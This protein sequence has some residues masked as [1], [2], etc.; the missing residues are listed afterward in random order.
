MAG[1]RFSVAGASERY[2]LAVAC[3]ILLTLAVFF[4]RPALRTDVLHH[5]DGAT[6]LWVAGPWL[7]WCLALVCGAR[8]MRRR[9]YLP[10]RLG[11]LQW[12]LLNAAVGAV[13]TLPFTF[14]VAEATS[15]GSAGTGEVD[16]TLPLVA[17]C[18]LG[19]AVVSLIRRRTSP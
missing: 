17:A 19:L 16:L 5:T 6:A 10:S 2:L 9:G 15:P 18:L 1:G 4:V 12:A 3:P 7:L 13:V 14:W 11:A 8:Y